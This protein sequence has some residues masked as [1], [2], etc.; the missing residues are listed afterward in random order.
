MRQGVETP[1]QLVQDGIKLRGRSI[2]V[3]PKPD[4]IIGSSLHGWQRFGPP[5]DFTYV[6]SFG[7]D[8][9]GLHEHCNCQ[10]WA[11]NRK[12][13]DWIYSQSLIDWDAHRVTPYLYKGGR[14][15]F[16]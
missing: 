9:I 12:D 13:I 6:H 7:S 16:I 3:H 10:N 15:P 2:H 4:R 14:L 1:E 8:T 11:C 5:S